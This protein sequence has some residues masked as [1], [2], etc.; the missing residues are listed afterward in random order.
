MIVNYHRPNRDRGCP[1]KMIK[2]NT[3]L[4]FLIVSTL[5]IGYNKFETSDDFCEEV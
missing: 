1:P 3:I 4:H 5:I 2:E